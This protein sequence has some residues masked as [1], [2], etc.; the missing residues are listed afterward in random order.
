MKCALLL[1]IRTA[2]SQ[3]PCRKAESG[4]AGLTYR[5]ISSAAHLA[6][7]RRVAHHR[8]RPAAYTTVLTRYSWL[9]ARSAQA[10]RAFLLAQATAARFF[11]RR[12]I[13][14]LSHRLLSSGF[15]STQRSV[16]RAPWTRSLR[17]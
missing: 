17:R 15:V 8:H 13:S 2:A 11:P 1:L 4:E 6:F 9:C 5:V 16:A 10:I 7:W 3:G 12:A 14:A